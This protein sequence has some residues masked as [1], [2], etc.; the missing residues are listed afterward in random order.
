M[1]FLTSIWKEFYLLLMM[2]QRIPLDTVP[3]LRSLFAMVFKILSFYEVP[4]E[5]QVFFHVGKRP[6]C[7]KNESFGFFPLLI[8][9]SFVFLVKNNID[10]NHIFYPC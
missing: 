5:K 3:T 9:N 1:H 10:K 6:S 4:S 8:I 7:T 2:G